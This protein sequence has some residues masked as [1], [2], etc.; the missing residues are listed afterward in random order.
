VGR[1]LVD[2]TGLS[3]TFDIDLVWTESTDPARPQGAN[4]DAGV[5]LF[6]ALQEQLGLRL[7]SGRSAF[8]VVA[9]EHIERPTPD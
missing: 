1:P 9:I 8:D 3:G 7:E 2:A 6:T 5:S 4:A